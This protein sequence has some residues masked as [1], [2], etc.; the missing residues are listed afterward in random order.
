MYE[1]DK[2]WVRGVSPDPLLVQTRINME[3]KQVGAV[4]T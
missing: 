2:W 1:K 3:N 4:W